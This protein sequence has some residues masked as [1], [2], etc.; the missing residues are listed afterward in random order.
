MNRV[1][2][3]LSGQLRTYKITLPTIAKF[4][5]DLTIDGKPVEVDYFIHSH[6]R[7]LNGLRRHKAQDFGG[8]RGL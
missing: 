4:F 8:R 6:R 3:C 1:A 2:V 7:Q 5:K